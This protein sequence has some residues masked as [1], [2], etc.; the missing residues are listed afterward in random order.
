MQNKYALP[1]LLT[2]YCYI[3]F[4]PHFDLMWEYKNLS[5]LFGVDRKLCPK[6]HCSAKVMPNSDPDGESFLSIPIYQIVMVDSF[7]CT[8]FQ[9]LLLFVILNAKHSPIF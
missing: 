4:E 8:P 9:F 3:R 5:W 2:H 1:G 6:G 7:P